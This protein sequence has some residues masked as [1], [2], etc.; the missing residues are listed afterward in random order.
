MR[1]GK[2]WGMP[3][4]LLNEGNTRSSQRHTLARALQ[5]ATTS[6]SGDELVTKLMEKFLVVKHREEDVR[7]PDYLDPTR[8]ELDEYFTVGE[9]RQAIFAF[10]GKCAPGANRITNRMLRNLEDHS[11]GNLTEKTNDT[12]KNGSVPEQWKTAN[13]VL[14]PQPGRAPNVDSLRPITLTSCVGKVVA[15]QVH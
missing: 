3:K 7:F 4:H 1:N 10:N 15:R 5:E 9:I 11:I 12:W 2:S 13:V 8:P 6:C 14:I